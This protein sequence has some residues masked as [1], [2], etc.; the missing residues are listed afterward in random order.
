MKTASSTRSSSG[1]MSPSGSST[2]WS[3]T[4]GGYGA[5]SPLECA[6][7]RRRPPPTRAPVRARAARRDR[8]V[9]VW[10]V[11]SVAIKQ[12]DGLNGLGVACYRIWLGAAL[13]TVPS[14]PPAAGSPSGCSASRSG[15][16]STFTADLVLF[17]CAVQETSIANA[18]DHRRAPAACSSSPWP[19]RC[20]ASG[21]G[22]AEVGVG[23]GGGGGHRDRG[24]RRRRRRRQQPLG[25]PAGGGA[26]VAWTAYFVCTKTAR[27]ELSAPSST[28][29]AWRSWSAVVVVPAAVH[30]STVRSGRTDAERVDDH[31]VPH[32]RQRAARALPHGVRPRARD[33]AHRLAAHAGD[34]GVLGG[35]RGAADR[36][37]AHAP[38]RWSAW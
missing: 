34:P 23:R 29:P 6:G 3:G 13:V 22:P 9:V 1:V 33:A 4:P 21:R 31:R 8:G 19:G 30:R 32:G 14:W 17:F 28:S 25:R 7:D 16:G 5:R 2:R 18:T 24:A 26:L 35:R 11:S 27:Q 38:C 10:G 15:A 20:S 37:A 36:R 12:V